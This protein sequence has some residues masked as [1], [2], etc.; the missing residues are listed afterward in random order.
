MSQSTTP[1]NP[2]PYQHG[3][4]TVGTTAQ[5]LFIVPSGMKRAHVYIRNNSA[6]ATIFIGDTTVAS[7]GS[8]QGLPIPSNTTQPLEFTGGTTI[9]VIASSASTSVSYLWTA[10][11]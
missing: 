11:N 1:A 9:S 7:S 6:S 2:S 10:G 5:T 4:I 3:T 8:T